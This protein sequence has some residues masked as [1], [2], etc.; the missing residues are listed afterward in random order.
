M[1]ARALFSE[2]L[3]FLE[4]A[5]WW[6]MSSWVGRLHQSLFEDEVTSDLVLLCLVS[7]ELAA[8]L[9]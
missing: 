8:V 4:F 2:G 9:W 5:S 1:E 3:S 6:G 7:V